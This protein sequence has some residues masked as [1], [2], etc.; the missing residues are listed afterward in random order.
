MKSIAAVLFL[1]LQ[2]VGSTFAAH[3]TNLAE[4]EKTLDQ[5][6]RN[7]SKKSPFTE[8]DKAL[9]KRLLEEKKLT[10]VDLSE[11]Q[12]LPDNNDPLY[13]AM[14]KSALKKID[15]E[16]GKKKKRRNLQRYGGYYGYGSGYSGYYG[17]SS[18]SSYG[19]YYG[20]N[21]APTYDMNNA[22][23]SI[24]AAPK[25][26]VEIPEK[27]SMV[28]EAFQDSRRIADPVKLD[29]TASY[30]TA[31]T[32]YLYD[33]EPLFNVV[34]DV[35]PGGN[36]GVYL[37]NERDRIAV[38][39]G[40]C[41]RTDPKSN[42]VGRS[43][44]Q[45]EYRFLDRSGDVEASIMAEGVITKGDIN[46]LS[47]TGGSGIFGRVVGTVVLE[48]GNLRSGNPPFFI[49]NDRLDLP[50]NYMAKMFLFMDSVDLEMLE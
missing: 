27:V 46:T 34:F 6:K 33:N 4:A 24:Y 22:M 7:L 13:E 32:T 43:Y 38:V 39:S 49:P 19:G 8:K 10:R 37:V 3:S 26:K 45:F 21:S 35:P 14:R 20:Y 47:I 31:G 1:G 40:T 36:R 42:Y 29:P 44:C 16:K 25:P 48:S 11:E 9:L 5:R 50:S 30:L 2:L 41:V 17:Y 23:N 12:Y 28:L 18:G 15:N